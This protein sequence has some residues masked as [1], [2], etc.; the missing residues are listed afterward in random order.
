VEAHGA[1]KPCVPVWVM[2]YMEKWLEE[3][4]VNTDQLYSAY[5]NARGVF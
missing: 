5:L 4:M 3:H 2:L 1:G